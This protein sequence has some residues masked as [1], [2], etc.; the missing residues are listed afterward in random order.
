MRA[1][2]ERAAE[3]R[4]RVMEAAVPRRNENHIVGLL[5]RRGEEAEFCAT[6][7]DLRSLDGQSSHEEGQHGHHRHR[8]RQ[9]AEPT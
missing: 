3:G 8:Q 2:A 6:F 5:E 7:F 1:I 9:F 4:V